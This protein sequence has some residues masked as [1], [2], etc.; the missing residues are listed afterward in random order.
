MM[1]PEPSA[2]RLTGFPGTCEKGYGLSPGL[3]CSKKRRINWSNGELGSPGDGFSSGS[4]ATAS[5]SVRCETD[6]FTTAGD[7]FLTSGAKLWCWINAVGDVIVCGTACVACGF[8]AQTNGDRASVVPSPKPSAAA[9]FLFS[10]GWLTQS[11]LDC[12][13]WSSSGA[14]ARAAEAMPSESGS[15]HNWSCNVT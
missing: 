8:S 10:Q 3:C 11:F 9:R 6:M 7:T 14:R 15:L 4:S 13:N 12:A 2:M 5:A 1:K